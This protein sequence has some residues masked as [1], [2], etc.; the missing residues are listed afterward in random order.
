MNN[1]NIQTAIN[2]AATANCNYEIIQSFISIYSAYPESFS[3]F[4]VCRRY[5][6]EVCL[7]DLQATGSYSDS[8]KEL[9]VA[10]IICGIL[11]SRINREGEIILVVGPI[12]SDPESEFIELKD[13]NEEII[14]KALPSLFKMS[15]DL[16]QN[17]E[18]V[19]DF[20]LNNIHRWNRNKQPILHAAIRK[21]QKAGHSTQDIASKLNESVE[22]INWY[23]TS[24][25]QE[26][27]LSLEMLRLIENYKFDDA[28]LSN[29]ESDFRTGTVSH[30]STFQRIALN[31]VIKDILNQRSLNG[32]LRSLLD[33][34]LN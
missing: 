17:P 2:K 25:E 34:S 14:M 15:S 27:L 13:L 29:A 32:S 31:R 8:D 7:N 19:N 10:M 20:V 33:F 22:R 26:E 5:E 6:N 28:A 21:L 1:F 12:S 18:K 9:I 24:L 23:N 16:I 30:L 4:P 11:Q 3:K